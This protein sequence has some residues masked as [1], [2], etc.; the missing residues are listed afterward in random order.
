MKK[1]F[2]ILPEDFRIPVIIVQ[3][4]SPLSNSEWIC[5]L[6]KNC[7]LNLKEADEKE[8]IEPGN[9]YIAP[10]NYH[11]LIE[12]DHTFS[13]TT[14][15]KVCY[16]RPS[17][18]VLFETAAEAFKDRLI[19]IVLTGS[20]H[21]GTAGLKRIKH[22]GGLCIVQDLE[23]AFSSYMPATAIAEVGPHHILAL[24]EIVSLLLILDKENCL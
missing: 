11:L 15:E 20:N 3:H 10:P 17:I 16:A 23:D 24:D 7:A 19:G 8:M 14:D 18:D 12:K 22:Y 1:L 6:N 13:L 2:S 9:I 21:D 5:I 4:L